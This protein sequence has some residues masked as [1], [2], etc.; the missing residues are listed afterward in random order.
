MNFD[1][2]YV[3]RDLLKVRLSREDSTARALAAQKRRVEE[4]EAKVQRCESELEEYRV[5]RIQR[6]AELYDEIMNCTIE[7]KELESVQFKVQQLRDNEHEYEGRVIQAREEL[8]AERKQLEA[9]KKAYHEAVQKREKLDEHKQIWVADAKRVAEM[10]AEK[11]LEDFKNRRRLV[12]T[13]GA[14][15]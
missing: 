3:L 11:E 8:D 1:K 12:A 14:E 2:K 4:A 5:W 9:D 15:V 13:A 6:E 10:S 7:Q